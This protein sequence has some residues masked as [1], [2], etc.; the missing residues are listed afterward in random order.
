MNIN[1]HTGGDYFSLGLVRVHG[2]CPAEKM[3][4][5]FTKRLSEFGL[6]LATDIIATTTDGASSM[7]KFGRLTEPLHFQ[8]YAHALQ[9][10]IQK[11]LYVKK[12]KLDRDIDVDDEFEDENSD[13]DDDN[14]MDDEYS[15]NFE[16]E[17]NDELDLDYL[18][19]IQKIRKIVKKFRKSPV[20][21]DLYLQPEV[22]K[23]L[24]KELKVILDCK[25]RWGS[26]YSMIKRFL[27]VRVCTGSKKSGSRVIG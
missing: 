25:T 12:E 10:A 1:V 21:N 9:L 14:D 11:V 6:D 8:C 22:K 4:Q 17:I 5:L 26:M 7:K 27:K 23:E 13:Q 19:L 3:V 15:L 18:A 24:G 20:A 16:Q 2:S